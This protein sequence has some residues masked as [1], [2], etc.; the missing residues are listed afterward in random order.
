M[1]HPYLALVDSYESVAEGVL[2]SFITLFHLYIIFFLGC[3]LLIQVL[4]PIQQV[5]TGGK[6]PALDK[7]IVQ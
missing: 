3:K 6:M 5:V 2:Q 4:D 7:K 1:I